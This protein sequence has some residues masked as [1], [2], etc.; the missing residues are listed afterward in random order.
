[1]A[2]DH[3][4]PYKEIIMF[5]QEALPLTHQDAESHFMARWTNA[6]GNAALVERLYVFLERFRQGCERVKD[7]LVFDEFTLKQVHR[8]RLIKVHWF[9]LFVLILSCWPGLLVI[10]KLGG[11]YVQIQKTCCGK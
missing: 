6:D 1:M 11:L 8:R 10:I 3:A 7:L 9:E 2:F 4:L 5:A